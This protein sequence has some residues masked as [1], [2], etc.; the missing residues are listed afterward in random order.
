VNGGGYVEVW[1]NDVVS[2]PLS[3]AAAATAGFYP[4]H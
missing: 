3:F 2:Y 4:S 1:S